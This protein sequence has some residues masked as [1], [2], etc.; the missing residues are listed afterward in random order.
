[1]IALTIIELFF[2]GGGDDLAAVVFAAVRADAMRALHLATVGAGDEM[3]QTERVVG[4]TLI[5]ARFRY[6]SL[7]NCTH[8]VFSSI[9]DLTP[10]AGDDRYLLSNRICDHHTPLLA[11]DDKKQAAK[12]RESGL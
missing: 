2:A 12:S 1:M 4:A 9:L 11:I 10:R 8:D 6:F 3:I 5:A 7:G